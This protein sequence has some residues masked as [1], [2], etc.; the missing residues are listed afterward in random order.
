MNNNFAIQSQE[1]TKQV[2]KNL[3]KLLE[4]NNQALNMLPDEAVKQRSEI[5]SDINAI[6]KAGK[7]GD[8]DKLQTYLKKNA[9]SS[10]R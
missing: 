3:D 6:L 9:D 2:K 4:L 5:Q 10:K 7:K 8:L 1:L